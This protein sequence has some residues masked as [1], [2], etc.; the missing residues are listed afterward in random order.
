MVDIDPIWDEPE[1]NDGRVLLNESGGIRCATLNKLI[2]QLTSGSCKSPFFFLSSPPLPISLPSFS[3]LPLLPLS[4]FPFPSF[5]FLPFSFFS[6]TFFWNFLSLLFPLFLLLFSFP[7]PFF[8]S[9]LFI[10]LFS[11]FLSFLCFLFIALLSICFFLIQI[12]EF[13]RFHS[14][15]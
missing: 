1:S 10:S 15:P 8:L 9:F 11:L 5:S 3:L 7:S 2:I 12:A 6:F 14:P 4:L 13:S